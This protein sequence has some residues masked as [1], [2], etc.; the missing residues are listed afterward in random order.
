MS[1]FLD[2]F[3]KKIITSVFSGEPQAIQDVKVDD[4]IALGVLLWI[5][6][7]ADKKFLP[8]EKGAIK[9]ILRKHNQLSDQ[10]LAVVLESIKTAAEERIDL[11]SFTHEVSQG[12]SRDMKIGILENIFR[13]ACVDNDLDHEEHEIIRKI[14]GLFRL[15]HKEFIDTKIKIKK[16]FG[17]DTAGL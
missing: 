14:S 7:Q 1:G 16:E 10:D 15:D 6:A 4:K 3:R 9:N 13:V 17:L 8:E 5:V 2:K 11:Y 12:L